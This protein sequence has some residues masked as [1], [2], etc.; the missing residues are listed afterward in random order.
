[1]CGL[2]QGGWELSEGESVHCE[3]AANDSPRQ[4]HRDEGE[5]LPE[6]EGGRRRRR[7]HQGRLLRRQA[8]GGQARHEA[9]VRKISIQI[10]F[11]NFGCYVFSCFDSLDVRA[12]NTVFLFVCLFVHM[13]V[14]AMQLVFMGSLATKD[15]GTHPVVT[16]LLWAFGFWHYITFLNGSKLLIVCL[17]LGHCNALQAVEEKSMLSCWSVSQSWGSN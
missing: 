6:E 3:A 13:P 7:P 16:A 11:V 17:F 9:Q 12:A 5:Q 14:E 4:L 8:G 1:M 15:S 10:V 2:P